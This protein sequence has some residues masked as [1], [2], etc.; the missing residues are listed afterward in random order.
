[1]SQDTKY[2]VF[3]SSTYTDLIEARSAAINTVLESYNF[4][5]GMELFG[6]D[7][8]E[9]WTII[10][11]LI[12]SSDFYILILGHRYGSISKE[13]GISFTEKEFDYAVN[14]GLK[15]ICFVRSDNVA[16][17]P[18]ERD[19]NSEN[20]D[21]L[22]LFRQ[23]VLTNRLCEFWESVDDL[24]HK[25][26]H[27]LYKNMRKHGGIGWVR[28]NQISGQLAEEL[29]K[30]SE[31]NRKLR[32]ENESL[33]KAT[34]VRE[35][36]LKI[37]INDIEIDKNIDDKVILLKFPTLSETKKFTLPSK[38]HA[39]IPA[40][41][42]F[43]IVTSTMNVMQLF[44]GKKPEDFFD[45]YNSDIDSLTQEDISSHN[46]YLEFLEQ[47]TKGLLQLKIQIENNGT[48]LAEKVSV[49]IKFP[50]FI[51]VIDNNSKYNFEYLKNN[52]EKKLINLPTPEQRSKKYLQ[53]DFY[54]S[55]SFIKGNNLALNKL[56][57]K[58]VRDHFDKD[59][60]VIHVSIDTLLHSKR[61]IF[62]NYDIFPNSKG[63]GAIEVNLICSQYLSLK[64]HELPIVVE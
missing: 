21:K 61:E 29:A 28:G 57:N 26:S 42:P 40:I 4:P 45:E 31:E 34:A 39:G 18:H 49:E 27:S 19:Q 53:P 10:K 11:E 62:N 50:E 15:L 52:L 46:R 36:D 12:D 56:A 44:G 59:T 8:D 9:Q 63:K 3:I 64:Y 55:S 33:K 41:S 51:S 7:N 25:I 47:L 58:T 38:R 60:N 2:Q 22:N 30:L 43:P 32:E 23:K 6:A 35:P 13:D 5:V 16:T 20:S 1:M 48:A 37:R 24:K 54:D 17:H 14:K